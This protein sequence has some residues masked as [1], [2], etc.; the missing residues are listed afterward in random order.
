M[1]I[2]KVYTTAGNG[3]LPCNT[4]AGGSVGPDFERHEF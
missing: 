4:Q 3:M 2:A 1:I